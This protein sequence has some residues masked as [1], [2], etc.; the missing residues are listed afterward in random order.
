MINPVITSRPT[1]LISSYLRQNNSQQ[2]TSPNSSDYTRT[3]IFYVNDFHGRAVNMERTITASNAFDRFTP[4]DEV[5]RLKLASGDIM[6][7]EDPLINKIAANFLKFI[8][9]TASAVGNHECDT[10]PDEIRNLFPS[11]SYNLLACNLKNKDNNDD[12]HKYIKSSIVE[13]HNGN[14]Y[15]IIGTVPTDLLTRLKYAKVFKEKDIAPANIDETIEMVQSEVDK[16]KAQGINKIILLSHSGY[17]YD[18]RIARATEGID[19][20]LGGHSHN[21]IK[22]IKENENLFTSKNGEPVIITQA[23]RDGKNFGV[24]NLEFDKNGIIKKA[25]N[26]VGVTRIFCRNA[27]A[28]HVFDT[29]LGKP[30]VVGYVRTAPPVMQNDLIDPSPLSNFVLDAVREDT[31]SEIAIITSAL[32]RGTFEKGRVD[33]RTIGELS[34]FKNKIVNARYSQK[35]LV[36]AIKFS[37]NS[38]KNRNNKPGLIYV[39]G[40]RYTV[41]K[42]GEL[43]ELSFV[44]KDGIEEKIDINNPRQDKTYLVSVND[45]LAVGGDNFDM[46]NKYNK[47]E[48]VFDYDLTKC[49]EDYFRRHPEPLD[50]IDDGRIK[51]VDE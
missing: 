32:L 13:E 30:E 15:G 27:T 7:G 16:L 22:D 37:A 14:K 24:L 45:Y 23:G 17:G 3:S 47:A 12:F 8:G 4:S 49:V 28:R 19:V 18:I 9:V 11:L 50:I 26:N 25:Q 34:P 48:K 31:G 33:T 6:L 21:L 51:I 2:K 39:S 41:T 40:L 36:D 35:E 38:F 5:D 29:I 42:N 1:N 44:N 43:K 10:K 46:L 20:I